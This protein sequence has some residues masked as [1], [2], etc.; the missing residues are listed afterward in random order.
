V[1]KVTKSIEIE[2]P[3][4]KVFAFINDMEK[5]S[6]FLRRKNDCKIAQAK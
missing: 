5:L 1:T 3:P 4:E 2:A 6:M